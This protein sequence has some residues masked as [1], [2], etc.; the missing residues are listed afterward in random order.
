M[1][2][3]IL[4]NF[5]LSHF[6]KVYG[7]LQ[8]YLCLLIAKLN[9]MNRTIRETMKPLG[10]QL[11]LVACILCTGWLAGSQSVKNNPPDAEQSPR[12]VNT[13]LI[14][15]NVAELVKFYEQVLGIKAK[16]SGNDYADF[17]TSRGVLAIFS[18]TAQEKYIPGSSEAAKNKSVILEFRV[19]NVDQEYSR[20]KTIIKTWVKLPNN[21]PW[22][23]RS[24]YFRDNDGN[25]VDFFEILKK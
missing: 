21:A 18:E 3:L 13:C 17:S 9:D 1:P 11:A 8:F 2:G 25:L 4:P 15:R 6:S 24:M 16:K 22:G 5:N 19:A 10:K 7:T 12:L 20:L 23:T 14:T